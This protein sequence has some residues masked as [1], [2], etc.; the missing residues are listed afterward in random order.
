[1]REAPLGAPAIGDLDGDGRPEIVL[2]TYV[3][4]TYVVDAKGKAVA[5]WPKRLPPV[6]SC[7]LDPDPAKKPPPGVACAGYSHGWARGAYAAPVLADFDGDKKLEIVQ[8][9]FDGNVYVFHA[10]GTALAGWPVAVHIDRA[11]KRNRIM[12]TP[13]VTDMNRDGVPDIATGSNET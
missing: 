13:L 8:A 3:G 6:L 4:T 1:G 11:S 9:A 5:P 10:D 2:T 12:S 7:P